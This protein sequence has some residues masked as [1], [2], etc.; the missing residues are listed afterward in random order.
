MRT[1]TIT[2]E[3]RETKILITLN[4]DKSTDGGSSVTTGIGFLDH[5]LTAFAVHGGFG[6]NLECK[7]DLEVDSHHT[8]EDV[9]IVLGKAIKEALGGSK[10]M[11]YGSARIPMDESLGWCTMDIS[12]RPFLVFRADFAGEKVGELDTQMVKE[13]M[14]A[15]AF[16]AGI[17]LHVGIDYGE[18]D[19]HKIEAMFKAFAYALKEAVKVNSGSNVI[20]TKG[21]LA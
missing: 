13:F 11:R 8:A 16:N 15:V 9:G 14:Q 20:S 3:T 17:T 1:S 18:N 21:M 6:L 10:I 4:L 12:G 7:G 2:R 5:M 19:H